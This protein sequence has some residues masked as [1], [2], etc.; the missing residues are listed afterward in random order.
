MAKN[1]ANKKLTLNETKLML[2]MLAS[3]V[4]LEPVM[5]FKAEVIDELNDAAFGLVIKETA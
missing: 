1:K 4:E 5:P 3:L 2:R